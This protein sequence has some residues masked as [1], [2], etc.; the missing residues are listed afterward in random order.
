MSTEPTPERLREMKNYFSHCVQVYEWIVQAEFN[1]LGIPD[2]PQPVRLFRLF[3]LQLLN[4]FCQAR[5]RSRT[6]TSSC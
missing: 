4:S 6:T 1:K 3:L 2:E 5:T